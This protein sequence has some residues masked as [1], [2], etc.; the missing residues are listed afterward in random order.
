M[1]MKTTKQ[2]LQDSAAAEQHYVSI[3]VENS[4]KEDKPAKLTQEEIGSLSSLKFIKIDFVV[5]NLPKMKSQGPDNLT[6]ELPPVVKGELSVHSAK[7]KS[8]LMHQ[9][10]AF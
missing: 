10:P 7:T 5:K 8:L 6:G 2:N 1:K 9:I 3:L 4:L